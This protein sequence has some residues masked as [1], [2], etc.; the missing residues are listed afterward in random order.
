MGSSSQVRKQR[1]AEQ[2]RW[3]SSP[4]PR[5]TNHT[6]RLQISFCIVIVEVQ[7]RNCFAQFKQQM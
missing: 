1:K 3:F 4:L 7:Y 2:G 6:A 5:F